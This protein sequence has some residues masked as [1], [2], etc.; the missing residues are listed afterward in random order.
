MVW[1][2]TQGFFI[3]F[4]V[5]VGYFLYI[6]TIS[7]KFIQTLRGSL[8]VLVLVASTLVFFILTFEQVFVMFIVGLFV[9]VLILLV[10]SSLVLSQFKKLAFFLSCCLFILSLVLVGK[11]CLL[12]VSSMSLGF[13]GVITLT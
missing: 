12:G 13:L 11:F 2:L 1:L 8:L 9:H 7:L 3:S 6:P 5:F 4:C 10:C